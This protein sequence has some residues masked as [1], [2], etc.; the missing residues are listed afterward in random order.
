[1]HYLHMLVD[2]KIVAQTVG[3]RI[4]KAVKDMGIWS[5]LLSK[6]PLHKS[7]KYQ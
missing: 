6:Q 3:I 5:N 1:M 7:H 2:R 4:H